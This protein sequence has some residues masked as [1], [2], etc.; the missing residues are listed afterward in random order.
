MWVLFI[1]SESVQDFLS[2]VYVCI[3]VGD[4]NTKK[5]G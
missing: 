5:G 4:P 3:V 1:K 2:F